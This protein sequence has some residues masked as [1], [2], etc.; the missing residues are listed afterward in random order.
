MSYSAIEYKNLQSPECKSKVRLDGGRGNE[1]NQ[2][3]LKG[4]HELT[5]G[6]TSGSTYNVERPHVKVGNRA[7]KVC[8]GQA[9]TVM[10]C[11]GIKFSD[12]ASQA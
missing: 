1:G 6:L 11:N 8:R 3:D 7:P 2:T 9:F 5:Y 10:H 12:I 4:R